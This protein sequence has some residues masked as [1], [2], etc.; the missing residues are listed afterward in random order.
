MNSH[1]PVLIFEQFF[2]VS[3]NVLVFFVKWYSRTVLTSKL[4]PGSRPIDFGVYDDEFEVAANLL[5]FSIAA[6]MSLP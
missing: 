4:K 3:K 6:L 1:I 5:P 2:A